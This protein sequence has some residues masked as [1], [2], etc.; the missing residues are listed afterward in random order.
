MWEPRSQAEPIGSS[1]HS[2]AERPAEVLS[3]H[4]CI[5]D[6]NYCIEGRFQPAQARLS[7][8]PREELAWALHTDAQIRAVDLEEGVRGVRKRGQVCASQRSKM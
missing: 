8:R 2:T 5:K 1:F 7:L 3:V 6:Q 4:L